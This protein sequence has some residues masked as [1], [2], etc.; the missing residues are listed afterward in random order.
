[1]VTTGS[2]SLKTQTQIP[3]YTGSSVAPPSQRT[4]NVQSKSKLQKGGKEVKSKKRKDPL[5]SSLPAEKPNKKRKT[6]KT[7]TPKVALRDSDDEEKDGNNIIINRAPVLQLWSACVA[8]FVYPSLP[9][10][11]CISAG[12]AISAICAVAKG[13][14][15]GT[16]AE[17]DT[18]EDAQKKRRIDKNKQED[19]HEIH[20]MQFTLKLKDGLAL[21]G[22]EQKGKPGDEETLK[23]KFGDQ[24]YQRTKDFMLECLEGWKGDAEEL[25]KKAFSFYEQ[26]RPD[27]SRGGQKG[28]G[29]KG[30]LKLQKMASVTKKTINNRSTDKLL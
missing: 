6:A 11:T 29:R 19:L 10:S 9:W 30:E 20:V 25:N 14:S 22:S 1:M 4:H 15:I 12:N 21:V 28:W 18:S 8:H 13:R 26:F 27:V 3:D 5:E 24:E 17:K 2:K 7:S 23:H 16:I